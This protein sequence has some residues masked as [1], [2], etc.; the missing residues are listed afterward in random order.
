MGKNIHI[1]SVLGLRLP[2]LCCANVNLIFKINFRNA[3]K[4]CART[5]SRTRARARFFKYLCKVFTCTCLFSIIICLSSV[6]ETK[7]GDLFPLLKL[8]I[9][10]GA[11]EIWFVVRSMNYNVFLLLEIVTKYFF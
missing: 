7:R 4:P 10:S 3:S 6:V 8:L 5:T 11:N 2:T 1:T 9:I